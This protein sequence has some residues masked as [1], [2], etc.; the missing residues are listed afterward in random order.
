MF[1]RIFSKPNRT[2]VHHRTAEQSPIS[3]V[4]TRQR[5]GFTLPT[6]EAAEFLDIPYA[7][8]V[9]LRAVICR[10]SPGKW[11]ATIISLSGDGGEVISVNVAA[12]PADAREIAATELDKCIH[13][14]FA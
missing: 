11:Q 5:A 4:E 10:L 6:W 13:D 8:G 7:D 1:L 3:V 2:T 12:T 9:M 14:P